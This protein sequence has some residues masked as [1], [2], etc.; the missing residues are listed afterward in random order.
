LSPNIIED[1]KK[2]LNLVYLS[3]SRDFYQFITNKIKLDF[4]KKLEELIINPDN[5]ININKDLLNSTHSELITKIKDFSIKN[6]DYIFNRRVFK[7]ILMTLP[8]GATRF[9]F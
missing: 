7:K 9:T 3:N 2:N 1:Y 6:S 8:Y 5:S 4:F